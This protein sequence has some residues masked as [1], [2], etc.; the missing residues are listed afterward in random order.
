[1]VQVGCRGGVC[2]GGSRDLETG[3]KKLALV[4]CVAMLENERIDAQ[5]N[6]KRRDL[7]GGSAKTPSSITEIILEV[8]NIIT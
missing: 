1:M 8:E 2:L 4:M 6:T 3:T 5:A 7:T